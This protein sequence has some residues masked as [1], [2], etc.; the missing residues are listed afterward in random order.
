MR[1]KVRKWQTLAKYHSPGEAN[2]HTKAHAFIPLSRWLFIVE[3]MRHGHVIARGCMATRVYLKICLMPQRSE[4]VMS[5]EFNFIWI[6]MKILGFFFFSS[7]VFFCVFPFCFRSCTA[8]FQ[9]YFGFWCRRKM[10]LA[11]SF[12]GAERAGSMFLYIAVYY[13]SHTH[14]QSATHI[15]LPARCAPA[16]TEKSTCLKWKR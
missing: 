11:T 13:V 3:R 5:N 4:H 7:F 9:C 16:F 10:E 1:V 6:E 15:P 2:T 12:G 8:S 14:I